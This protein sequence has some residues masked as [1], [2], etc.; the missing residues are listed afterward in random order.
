MWLLLGGRLVL[1]KYVLEGIL[2]Y[3]LSLESFPKFIQEKIRQKCFKFMWVGKKDKGSYHLVSWNKIATPEGLR[4]WG[5]KNIFIFGT[6][7]A[8]NSM[9]RC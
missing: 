8:T 4:G 1:V 3:Q 2:V 5:L 9:W 7:L 6:S